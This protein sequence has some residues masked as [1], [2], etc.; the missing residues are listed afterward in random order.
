M[1]DSLDL[2]ADNDGILDVIEAG[3]S[4]QDPDGDGRVNGPFGDNGFADSLETTPESGVA[5]FTAENTDGDGVP[6]FQD[7]DSD[8]DSIPDVTESD[9]SDPDQDGI[10]GTGTPVVNEDG[11]ANDI[12]PVEGGR[13]LR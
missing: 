4:E 8:N 9:G 6:D 13:H 2:D 1:P 5:N 10:I 11:I 3:H 7:L 12:N